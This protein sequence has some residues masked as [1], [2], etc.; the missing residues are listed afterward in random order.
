MDIT[1]SDIRW[2]SSRVI[3]SS[4]EEIQMKLSEYIFQ[5]YSHS[6]S[7]LCAGDIE[8]WIVEWYKSEFRKV[9]CDGE[10]DDNGD[11]SRLPPMWLANWRKVEND[12][13]M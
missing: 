13:K 5:Q 6:V 9:G 3:V 12:N 8:R 7:A 10:V 2:P 1:G 4:M 11:V